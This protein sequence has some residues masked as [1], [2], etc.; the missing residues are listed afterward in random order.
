MS[1]AFKAENVYKPQTQSGILVHL[2]QAY[3]RTR[4]TVQ[5]LNSIQRLLPPVSVI[6]LAC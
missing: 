3:V 6:S 2:K 1:I 4:T 5:I